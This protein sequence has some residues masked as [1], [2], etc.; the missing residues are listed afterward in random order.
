MDYLLGLK[1]IG[2]HKGRSE[3]HIAHLDSAV[4]LDPLLQTGGQ[5][6]F[7][8][9]KCQEQGGGLFGLFSGGRGQDLEGPGPGT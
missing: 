6:L 4:F 8:L 2:D 7:Y 1:V 5:L 9:L 3:S